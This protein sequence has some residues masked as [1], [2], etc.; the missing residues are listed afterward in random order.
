MISFFLDLSALYKKKAGG[1]LAA[2]QNG[3]A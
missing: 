3:E 2:P 1:L